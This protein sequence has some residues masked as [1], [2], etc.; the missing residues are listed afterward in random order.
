[1]V[2]ANRTVT[3]PLTQ[4]F[5]GVSNEAM[6]SMT[7][8]LPLNVTMIST[9]T[10]MGTHAPLGRSTAHWAGGGSTSVAGTGTETRS[11]EPGRSSSVSTAPFNTYMAPLGIPTPFTSTALPDTMR[12]PAGLAGITWVLTCAR[13]ATS[14][15]S[16]EYEIEP[17]SGITRLDVTGIPWPDAVLFSPKAT[18]RI[19]GDRHARPMMEQA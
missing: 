13:P 16:V 15:V 2:A 11:S 9:R 10:S 4:H 3:A 12:C 7:V 8:P 6:P 1:M 5:Y 19:R 18:T 14:T 17:R